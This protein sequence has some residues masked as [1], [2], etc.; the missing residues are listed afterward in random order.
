MSMLGTDSI[1]FELARGAIIC[2]PA[3]TQIESAHIDVRLGEYFWLFNPCD[4]WL[5]DPTIN[6]A[7]G[8]DLRT[9]D[10]RE[11]FDL[12]RD[13]TTITI[14]PRGFILAHTEEFIGTAA[15]AG[16]VPMLHTRST[17]AR[18]GVS[19]HQSAGFGDEGFCGRWTLEIVNPHPTPIHLP[20][21]GR[22]GCIAF[23]TVE[24]RSDP[25]VNRYNISRAD[26]TPEAMLPRQGNW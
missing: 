16:I 14:P 20:V 10:P 21:G 22:V 1:A 11:W 12:C 24:G 19:V 6:A 18:W 26:W 4:S 13:D 25:Y 2:D 5:F 23:E 17:M 15:H 3:P 8:L 9:A 7:H